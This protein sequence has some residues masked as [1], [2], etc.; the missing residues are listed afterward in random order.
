MSQRRNRRQLKLGGHCFECPDCGV[1]C[2]TEAALK[3]HFAQTL[4]EDPN[5]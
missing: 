3:N 5:D 4:C 2:I 1:R